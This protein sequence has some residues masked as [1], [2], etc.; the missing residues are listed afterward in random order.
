MGKH[1]NVGLAGKCRLL[2][3]KLRSIARMGTSMPKDPVPILTNEQSN[4]HYLCVIFIHVKKLQSIT[5]ELHS[6]TA[7]GLFADY[8]LNCCESSYFPFE[9]LPLAD[10]LRLVEINFLDKSVYFIQRL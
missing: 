8:G 5:R 10:L 6:I 9:L 4:E 1:E 3:F 2:M 7:V